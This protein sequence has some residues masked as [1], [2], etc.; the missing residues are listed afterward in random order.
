M[1]TRNVFLCERTLSVSARRSLQK[2]HLRWI[3]APRPVKNAQPALH[4]MKAHSLAA[5]ARMSFSGALL[6]KI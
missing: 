2:R 3:R 4:D 1:N 5:A 6:Q